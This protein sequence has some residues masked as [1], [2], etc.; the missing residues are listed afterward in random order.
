VREKK[1]GAKGEKPGARIQNPEGEKS[2]GRFR[3]CAFTSGLWLLAPGFFLPGF[4]LPLA[5]CAKDKESAQQRSENTLRDPMRYSPQFE[6][7]DV[8]GGGLLDY[9]RDGMRKDM[10]NVLDP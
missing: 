8:S 7:T 3:V 1:P 9:D 2:R 5:G 6:K 4:F 10:K